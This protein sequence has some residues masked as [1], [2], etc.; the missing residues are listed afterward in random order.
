MSFPPSEIK[1]RMIH[2][3]DL[4]PDLI[5]AWSRIQL[6]EPSLD[7]PFFCPEFTQAVAAAGEDV[8][9]AIFEADGE[10]AGFFP[11]QLLSTKVGIPVGSLICDFQGMIARN[12]L[13]WDPHQILKG[14]GLSAW[15]FDHLL[16]SQKPFLS[17]HCVHADSPFM[18]LTGGYQSYR[19]R[20]RGAGSD[21]LVQAE[22]KRRKAEREIGPIRFVANSTDR[23]LFQ[24]L[25]DWKQHQIQQRRVPFVGSSNR[26]QEIR[27]RILY[28]NRE[29]FGGMLSAVYIGDR[30]AAIH[31]GMR[32]KCVLHVWVPAFDES[33]HK[34]SPGMIMWMELAKTCERM[35][36]QRMDLGKGMVDY[37]KRLMSGTTDL[38]EGVV[39]ARPISRLLWRS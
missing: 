21:T 12:D 20:Q 26:F 33:F 14:C 29:T 28:Q 1:I 27:E 35:G 38:A 24:T 37:K 19:D 13:V 31:F 17:F 36:I 3:N 25:V 16:A 4:S 32:S 39:D 7:N 23:Q 30:L 10:I 34:Y 8:R 9:V 18:D 2:G 11:F 22:R 15:R 5:E 6:S